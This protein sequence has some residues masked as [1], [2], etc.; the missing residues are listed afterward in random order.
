MKKSSFLKEKVNVRQ[1]K[2]YEIGPPELGANSQN[3]L[4]LLWKN[5]SFKTFKSFFLILNLRQNL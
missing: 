4:F 1:K 3:L 2:F 5:E